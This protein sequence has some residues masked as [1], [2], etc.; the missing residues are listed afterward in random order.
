MSDQGGLPFDEDEAFRKEEATWWIAHLR[1][2]LAEGGR[3][4]EAREACPHCNTR[5]AA[6]LP[7]GGQNTVRCAN[8]GK[9]L[10][11]APKTE[12]GEQPRT[13]A[14]VRQTIRPSQQARIFDR[15]RARCVLCGRGDVPLT[16]GHLM[17]VADGLRLGASEREISDDVN[18]AAMCES[19][20]S[21]LG[22]RSVTPGTYARILLHLI[23]ATAEAECNPVAAADL[24]LV[25]H[26]VDFDSAR[27]RRP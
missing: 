13:V 25:V 7:R 18:L 24:D 1:E 23:R 22:R 9:L 11:N 19:C 27:S 14:T 2:I 16:I 21:G 4:Y 8:C 15:D 5:N 17:S 12:T 6:L 3:R 10:Y 20:N 26:P